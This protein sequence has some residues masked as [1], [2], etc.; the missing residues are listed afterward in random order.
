MHHLFSP[1]EKN[2]AKDVLRL[3]STRKVILYG[4]INAGQNKLKGYHL[5]EG[6]LSQLEK[7]YSNDD[8]QIV[9]FGE[10]KSLDQNH[11]FETIYLGNI[12]DDRLLL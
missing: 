11:Q 12:S 4:A 9:I 3:D 7:T 10:S 5:L 1:I 8:L 6:A 2:C